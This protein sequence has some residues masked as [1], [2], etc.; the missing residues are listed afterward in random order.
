LLLN[1]LDRNVISEEAVL[2]H[3]DELPGIEKIRKRREERAREEGGLPTKASPFHDPQEKFALKK[4]ALQ[5]GQ[6]TPSE[7]GL[8]LDDKSPGEKSVLDRQ[9]KQVDKQLQAQTEMTDK[10]HKM[11]KD[12]IK[13]GADQRDHEF[14]MTKLQLKH[15]VHPAQI[16]N[17]Q[18]GQ[19][20]QGRPKLSKDKQQR[21]QKTVKPRTAANVIET[22]S[23]AEHAQASIAEITAPAFLKAKGK[24][25]RRQLTASEFDDFERFTFA[26]LCN[27]P[28]RAE[29]NEEAIK[30]ALSQPLAVPDPI[31]TAQT[32]NS[33]S[34]HREGRQGAVGRAGAPD[35]GSGLRPLSQRPGRC[36]YR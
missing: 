31:V 3:F 20:G 26:V 2:K 6:A 32:R 16:A 11:Q 36:I 9:E 5:S 15:G 14:N 23:W 18:K 28:V 10:Q 25:N 22:T 33:D 17:D 4:I 29:V 24:K 30:A 1:L 27:L 35:S 21:K 12:Q 8:E 13:D 34:L 7:V 19:P